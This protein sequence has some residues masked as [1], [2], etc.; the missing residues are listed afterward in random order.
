MAK[1]AFLPLLLLG[2]PFAASALELQL[3]Q[4]A[5][6]LFEEHIALDGYTLPLGPFANG[7]MPVERLEGAIHR[8]S[9]RIGSQGL[10]SLQLMN[11]LQQ[12]LEAAG[13]EL[14][15]AC[16]TEDCGGFDFRFETE[17]LQAPAMHVDL[18]DFRFLS[19]RRQGDDHLSLLVSRSTGA[20]FVQLIRVTKGTAPATKTT[21]PALPATTPV[22]DKGD[23][24]MELAGNGHVVLSDLN[25]ETGSST[26]GAGPFDSLS[27]LAAYLNADDTLRLALVGHTDAVGALDQNI[28]L[29]KRRA[30]S[31]LERLV[32]D[33]G[34]ARSQLSAEGMGYLSPLGP[35]QTAAGRESN[36]RVEAVLLNTE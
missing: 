10:T 6:N 5:T 12:Q 7:E 19:A 18:S 24:I 4:G 1:A 34:V 36:R 23:L 25:F 32:S 15:F 22:A 29:S 9:W 30:A 8:Q 16:D 11:P 14:L 13:Y 33:Y 20:G 31:V 21:T 3:P 28:A 2:T 17:V 26:L 35:N 27:R